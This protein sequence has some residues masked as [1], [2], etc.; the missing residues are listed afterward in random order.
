MPLCGAV[1]KLTRLSLNTD[2][3]TLRTPAA[4]APTV[5]DCLGGGI[6]SGRKE[7]R[8][9]SRSRERLAPIH[10]DAVAVGERWRRG[11][12]QRRRRGRKGCEGRKRSRDEEKGSNW[13]CGVDG[14]EKGVEFAQAWFSIYRPLVGWLVWWLVLCALPQCTYFQTL[15]AHRGAAME[16]FFSVIMRTRH[17]RDKW[18]LPRRGRWES[19]WLKR[20]SREEATTLASVIARVDAATRMF[21]RL[22]QFKTEIR[23][24]L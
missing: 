1:T 13:Q 19:Y 5:W 7:S 23:N 11:R 8:K 14:A 20:S 3:C 21:H 15:N 24:D 9:N 6:D 16:R 12:E 10:A 4:A 22:V 17:S 2:G 18:C